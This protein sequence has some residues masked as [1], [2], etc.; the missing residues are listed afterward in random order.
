MGADRSQ[1]QVLL[2]PGAELSL[3]PRPE[4]CPREQ[5]CRHLRLSEVTASCLHDD[6][7]PLQGHR[8]ESLM[9]LLEH[10]RL[11]SQKACGHVLRHSLSK[12]MMLIGAQSRRKGVL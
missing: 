10:F 7:L 9:F 4:R 12:C 2:R 8:L 1:R 6:S 5:E 11:P 3:E